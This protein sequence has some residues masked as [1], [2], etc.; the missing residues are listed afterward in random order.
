MDVAY[1]RLITVVVCIG[2]S[3]ASTFSGRVH[4]LLCGVATRSS[5]MTGEHLLILHYVV[6][7]SS[8]VGN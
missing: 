7:M 6:V 2:H 5:Q 1:P 4:S 8:L 3:T